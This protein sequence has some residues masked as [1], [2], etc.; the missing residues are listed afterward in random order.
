MCLKPNDKPA[1]SPDDRQNYFHS[2]SGAND[3]RAVAEVVRRRGNQQ[4]WPTERRRCVG[5]GYTRIYSIYICC[6]IL[7]HAVI[8]S[9]ITECM[10]YVVCVVLMLCVFRFCFNLKCF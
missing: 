1:V 10:L 5:V 3:T 8:F 4:R 9:S 7:I 2:R 6:Y